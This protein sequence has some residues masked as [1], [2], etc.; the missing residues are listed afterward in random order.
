MLGELV[1]NQKGEI[2]VFKTANNALNTA[3][4]YVKIKI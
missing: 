1:K 2:A 4:N 3:S